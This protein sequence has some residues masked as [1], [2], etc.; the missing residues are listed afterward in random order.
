[1]H[2]LAWVPGCYC[3]PG[4]PVEILAATRDA[5]SGHPLILA[6]EGPTVELQ[7]PLSALLHHSS[8]A[9]IPAAGSGQRAMF[10]ASWRVWMWILHSAVFLDVFMDYSPSLSYTLR[11]RPKVHAAN[12]QALS[13]MRAL[14][15]THATQHAAIGRRERGVLEH[16]SIQRSI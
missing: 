13:K 3:K 5:P 12:P 8:G 16:Y 10:R 14:P 4:A 11:Y 9:R 15:T 1:M 6:S 7:N 2:R